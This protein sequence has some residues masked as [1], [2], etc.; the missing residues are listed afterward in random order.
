MFFNFSF[1]KIFIMQKYML[2]GL[3]ERLL[4]TYVLYGRWK[5][6]A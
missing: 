2:G 4:N 6:F 3:Y 1:T 5:L